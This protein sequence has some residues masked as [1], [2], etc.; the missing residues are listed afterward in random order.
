MWGCNIII[1]EIITIVLVYENVRVVKTAVWFSF[2]PYSR[3]NNSST[4]AN[5]ISIGAKGDV[6]VDGIG[7]V[8]D[9]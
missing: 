3:T 6:H 8:E 4:T 5:T 9:I 7:D 2:K 1:N